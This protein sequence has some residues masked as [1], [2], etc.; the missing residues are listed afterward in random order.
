VV[1]DEPEI[2]ANGL[3]KLILVDENGVI[4]HEE[5]VEI[6]SLEQLVQLVEEHLGVVL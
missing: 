5:Y 6:T 1:D 3:P 4:A 2:R